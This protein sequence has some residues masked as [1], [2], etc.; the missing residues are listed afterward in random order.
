MTDLIFAAT[1]DLAGKVRGKAFPAED[2]PKRLQR[3]VG[4]TPTN[5]QINCFND[6]GESPFGALGDL[7]LIPDDAAAVTAD[8][9][10]HVERFM[11]GDIVTLDGQA[12]DFCTRGL[13]KAALKRLETVAG[14]RLLAAFEHEF[15]VVGP[16]DMLGEGYG[17]GGFEAQR[18]LCEALVGQIAAAGLS[19][20]TIM[21]EYGANQYEVV[22]GPEVGVR[23]ADAAVILR[24]L[25]RS[26]A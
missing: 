16:S 1:C 8:F 20:D 24:E 25:T 13:L 22:I 10:T 7:L 12:W 23:A 14:V 17:R 3:G 18:E 21:K 6:I 2:L 26:T 4:W 19:P 11:L 9:G 15:H 5:V